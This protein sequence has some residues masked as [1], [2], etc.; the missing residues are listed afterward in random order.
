V[1]KESI[2]PASE[3]VTDAF[4]ERSTVTFAR[5]IKEASCSHV[6]ISFV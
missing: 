6:A 1:P 4:G 5:G 2:N 3:E